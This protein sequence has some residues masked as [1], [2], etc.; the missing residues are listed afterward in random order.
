MSYY[1]ADLKYEELSDH[2]YM[3][4]I[5]MCYENAKANYDNSD[6]IKSLVNDLVNF[7]TNKIH[8]ANIAICHDNSHMIGFTAYK[9]NEKNIFG[10]SIYLEEVCTGSIGA[11]NIRNLN[12]IEITNQT[13]PI[14]IIMLKYILEKY[15][16]HTLFGITLKNNKNIEIYKQQ[17]LEVGTILFPCT[18]FYDKNYVGVYY[19]TLPQQL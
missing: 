7:M 16:N 14:S 5:N 6:I 4:L 1:I 18:E 2:L 15:P 19:P 11:D 8:P 10:E 3:N 9:T 13:D 12:N 17:G